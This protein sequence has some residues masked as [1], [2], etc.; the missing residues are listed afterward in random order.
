MITTE[1][2]TC[3]QV[4]EECLD[5]IIAQGGQ[6]SNDFYGCMYGDG[7]G[8]HCG[9]GWLLPETDSSLMQ[10]TGSVHGLLASQRYDLGPNAEFINLYSHELRELQVLH[11]TPFMYITEL[12]PLVIRF[13]ALA[14]KAQVWI[15]LIRNPPQ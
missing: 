3:V 13:P 9:V 12:H 11:D 1:G 7:A 14:E 15:D 10:L 6:C 4:I 8:K 5:A 2:K